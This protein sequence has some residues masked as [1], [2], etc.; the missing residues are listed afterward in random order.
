MVSYRKF[1]VIKEGKVLLFFLVTA[2]PPK[3]L[4]VV[5][6]PGVFSSQADHWVYM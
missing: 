6:G 3:G 5:G 4:E 2:G 1:L